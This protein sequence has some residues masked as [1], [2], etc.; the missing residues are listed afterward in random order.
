M[1]RTIGLETRVA[2]T[3]KIRRCW[4]GEKKRKN[5]KKRERERGSI[6]WSFF[7]PPDGRSLSSESRHKA[8]ASRQ[9]EKPSSGALI[10][11]T[12][13]VTF[14]TACLFLSR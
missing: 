14:R 10:A 2:S 3:V 8:R 1:K 11:S 13:T 6:S 5:E 4:N 9:E 7:L 12:V